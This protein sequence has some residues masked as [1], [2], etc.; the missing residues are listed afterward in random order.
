[1]A[2]TIQSIEP[3]TVTSDLILL[4]NQQGICHDLLSTPPHT[5]ATVNTLTREQAIGRS[6]SQ[7]LL[8]VFARPIQRALIGQP[9]RAFAV[10]VTVPG[11]AFVPDAD[12]ASEP[13]H[14]SLQVTPAYDGLLLCVIRPL[15]APTPTIPVAV[16]QELE[17]Y[18]NIFTM[19]HVSV[20]VIDNEGVI[21]EVNCT[22]AQL[23]GYTSNELL[24]KSIIT[25]VHEE[26]RER[27]AARLQTLIA[28]PDFVRSPTGVE[29][30]CLHRSGRTIWLRGT[31]SVQRDTTGMV[32]TAV[33]TAEDITT[34]KE[35]QDALTLRNRVLETIPQSLVLTD[36]QTPGYPIIYV[37][38]GFEKLTGYSLAECLGRNCHFLQG[39]ETDPNTVEK[40][41]QAIRAGQPIFIELLNYRKDGTAFWNALSVAPV[42]NQQGEVTHFIS[43]QTDVTERKQLETQY[44][45]IQKMEAIGRLAGGVA[46]DFNNILTVVANYS[47]IVLSLIPITNPLY[48]KV[49]QIQKAGERAAQLTQQ[50]L[51]F[52]R[53]QSMELAP[54]NLNECLDHLEPIIQ[55]ITGEQLEYTAHLASDLHLIE[56]DQGHLE[57]AILNLMLNAKEAMP[58]GGTVQLQTQN[59]FLHSADLPS[60]HQRQSSLLAG[61]YVRLT[62]R[63]NGQGMNAETRERM[64]EPFFTTKGGTEGSGLGLSAVYGTVNQHNGFIDVQ[65]K[66][67]AGTTIHLYFPRS[68]A[69]ASALPTA[70]PAR[71]TYKDEA[72]G[73]MVQKSILVVDDE[74]PILSLMTMILE[75]DGY[76]VLQ[77]TN[78][79]E[80]IDLFTQEA[81]AVDLLLTDMIMPGMNGYDLYET[82]AQTTPD[83]RVIFVSGYTELEIIRDQSAP[84]MITFLAKPFTWEQLLTAVEKM[85]AN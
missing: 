63:D 27:A 21:I 38:P 16:R 15:T 80:A 69:P 72:A 12:A 4:L 13:V 36:A 76:R 50:L 20:A 5:A 44:Q 42:R 84:S 55:R 43:V 45:Q 40:L 67:G 17:R 48:T 66:E 49:E 60:P 73:N 74:K 82:L 51:T 10:E 11:Q 53:R 22:F 8:P 70:A 56:G 75:E 85:L 47:D 33:I 35:T 2:T 9:A 28:D 77:A 65:S 18:R 58:A 81:Q 62:V 14:F 30:R 23:F 37:N 39:A 24:G 78:A 31:L 7:L 68:N 34:T 46:H 3:S 29:R 59:L 25:L 19:S 57:Q 71:P 1:M 26:E 52:S 83:L 41:H 64:F 54:L 79:A 6:I 32:H 61:H